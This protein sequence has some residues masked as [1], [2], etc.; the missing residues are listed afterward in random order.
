MEEIKE[1]EWMW[2]EKVKLKD[3]W[4]QNKFEDSYEHEEYTKNNN[5]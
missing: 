2:E 3:F 5:R 1:E 4:K